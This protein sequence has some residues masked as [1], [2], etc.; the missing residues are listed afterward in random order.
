M[1]ILGAKEFFQING[2]YLVPKNYQFRE[3]I[4]TIILLDN[5]I[6]INMRIL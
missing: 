3:K 6:N 5:N 4:I 1:E 2:K